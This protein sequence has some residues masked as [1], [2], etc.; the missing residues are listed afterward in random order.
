MYAFGGGL[1]V[2]ATDAMSIRGEVLGQGFF[3]DDAP[4][5]GGPTAAKATV[6]VLFHF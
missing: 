6:G 5:D 4:N 3:G 2:A 1:E